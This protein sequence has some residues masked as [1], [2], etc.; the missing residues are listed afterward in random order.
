VPEPPAANLDICIQEIEGIFHSLEWASFA[1]D[2]IPQTL[3][4]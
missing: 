1:K 2:G 4:P 3:K